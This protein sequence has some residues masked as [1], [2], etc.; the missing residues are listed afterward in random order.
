MPDSIHVLGIITPCVF[1][2]GDE[3]PEWRIIMNRVVGYSM[4]PKGSKD[5]WP[6][7]CVESLV[8]GFCLRFK[9]VYMDKITEIPDYTWLLTLIIWQTRF[10]CG[11]DI[12][13][14]KTLRL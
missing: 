3:K 10:E 7:I 9:L 4:T 1:K 5:T 8:F 14:F 12:V 11:I 2:R 13:E 6:H